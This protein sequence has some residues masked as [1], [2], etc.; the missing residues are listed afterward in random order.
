M[1]W[2]TCVVKRPVQPTRVIQRRRQPLA[3]HGLHELA[4]QVT[5]GV[6]PGNKRVWLAARPQQKSV[7][8][9]GGQHGIACV[10]L[11]KQRRPRTRIP[12]PG[13]LIEHRRKVG[14]REI[15]PIRRRMVSRR[16]TPG[17]AIRIHVPFRV[18]VI[19][20][21]FAP[22]ATRQDLAQFPRPRRPR[23]HRIQPPVD[24]YPQLCIVKP[25]RASDA[26]RQ[27]QM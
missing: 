25:S 16:R 26:P 9:L 4:H 8:M 22:I 27:N 3:A 21:P 5:L 6:I 20:K 12:L 23:R 18:R 19:G 10:H 2:I 15:S 11:L 13:S 7:M 17:N 24:E 14:I 1:C